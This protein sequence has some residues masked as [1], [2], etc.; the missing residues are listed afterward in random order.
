MEIVGESW[1]SPE[2]Y[3]MSAAEHTYIQLM[4]ER[5]VDM[6]LVL[7]ELPFDWSLLIAN[8]IAP[9]LGGGISCLIWYLWNI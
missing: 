5:Y 1:S 7:L 4:Y 8:K 2:L 6:S 9:T 3:E